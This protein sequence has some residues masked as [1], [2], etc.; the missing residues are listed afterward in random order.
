[1]SKQTYEM[2]NQN[3][4][5]SYQ[6]YPLSLTSNMYTVQWCSVQW[7]SI[8][9]WTHSYPSQHCLFGSHMVEDLGGPGARVKFL[10]HHHVVVKQPGHGREGG[11]RERGGRHGQ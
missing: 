10:I 4:P 6:F 5:W 7:C 2:A 1:M 3:L 9:R 8:Q 11:E